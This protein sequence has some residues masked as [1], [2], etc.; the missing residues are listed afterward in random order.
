MHVLCTSSSNKS[1]LRASPRNNSAALPSLAA[2]HRDCGICRTAVFKKKKKKIH[3][4]TSERMGGKHTHLSFKPQQNPHLV[5]R[6]KPSHRNILSCICHRR[7]SPPRLLS[8]GTE[9]AHRL[10]TCW[11][12]HWLIYRWQPIGMW[13][14]SNPKFSCSSLSNFNIGHPTYVG[15]PITNDHPAY[16]HLLQA[17]DARAMAKKSEKTNVNLLTVLKTFSCST[18]DT[19]H[20][21]SVP[22][23][24]LDFYRIQNF[25]VF[26]RIRLSV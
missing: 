5:L 6:L 19:L 13:Q 18:S 21:P 7:L 20:L 9:M 25:S 11:W 24:L 22:A 4:K 15:Q 17:F 10:V 16:I 8:V 26:W 2:E 23:G 14:G 3:S 1:C 12:C